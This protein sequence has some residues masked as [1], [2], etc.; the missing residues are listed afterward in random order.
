TVFA[1]HGD[2]PVFA[3]S[4]P[5][6]SVVGFVT[7]SQTLADGTRCDP[8]P[9]HSKHAITVDEALHLMTAGSA[10]ALDREREVGSV[11]EGKLADLVVLSADPRQVSHEVLADL[12]VELT[13]L[14]GEVVHCGATIF[15]NLCDADGSDPEPSGPAG[16]VPTASASLSTNPPALA[17]DGDMETH[18]GAG[19][20]APQ[21]IEIPLDPPRRVVAVRLVVDQFPPG[22]TTH[23]VWGRRADNELVQLAERTSDTDMFDVLEIAIDTPEELVAIRIETT[24]SPSWVAWREIEIVSD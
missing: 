6:A 10:Y 22:P 21:W 18:W 23:V 20:D 11:E 13:I 15:A 16:P 19:A 9:Y 24:V 5:M 3:D 12:S 1:W 7:R 8:E 2:Y 4:G 17:V 14:G